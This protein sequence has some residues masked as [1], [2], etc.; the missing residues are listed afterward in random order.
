MLT[1][2]LV[3]SGLIPRFSRLLKPCFTLPYPISA[4]SSSP[5]PCDSSF[6]DHIVHRISVLQWM[7]FLDPKA[8]KGSSTE[9]ADEDL[10]DGGRGDSHPMLARAASDSY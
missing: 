7:A 9:T 8:A 4:L 5:I 2:I 10:R 6:L 1:P 3:P